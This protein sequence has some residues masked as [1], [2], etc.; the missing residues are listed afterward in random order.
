MEAIFF[1]GLQAS[2]KTS[3]YR[4]RFFHTHVRISL[5]L[6]NT[7]HREKRFLEICLE[8]RQRFVLDNT[9]PT[10]ADRAR[11]LPILKEA[12]YRVEA[13][14]FR[15]ELKACLQRN[16]LR[17]EKI[18]GTALFATIKK[19]ELPSLDEGFDK[20]HYVELSKSGFEVQAWKDEI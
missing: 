20:L 10:K 1:I 8:T 4:E 17:A 11:Y 13:Y 9:H 5:D 6:L 18:P 3:F 12:D 15:S 7:R 2:G 16:Q 19:L 14:Y